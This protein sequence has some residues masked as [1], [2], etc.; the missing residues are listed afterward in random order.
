LEGEVA[1]ADCSGTILLRVLPPPPDQG[2]GELVLVTTATLPSPGPFSLKLPAG[3]GPVVVQAVEDAD[4]NG[5]PDRGER[6]G[7]AAGGP[8]DGATG[9]RGLAIRIEAGEAPPA[10]SDTPATGGP[11]PAP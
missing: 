4:Q 2:G 3:L 10:G 8:H 6:I 9:A 11:P 7:F 1:C 5:R